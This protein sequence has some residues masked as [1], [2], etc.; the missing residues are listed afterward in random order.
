MISEFLEL[1]DKKN[2]QKSQK[3]AI[4]NF[5]RFVYNVDKANFEEL[6][7]EYIQKHTQQE[8]FHDIVKYAISLQSK[9]RNTAQT[10]LNNLQ[11]FLLWYDVEFTEKQKRMIQQK[12]N[13]A[14]DSI[15]ESILTKDMIRSLIEHTDL[16]TRSLILTL[17][18]SGMRVS[19]AL[20]L[21]LSDIELDTGCICIKK[22][23][24]K[25]NKARYTFMS[26]EALY[27]LKE[28]LKEREDYINSTYKRSKTK[29]TEIELIYPFNYVTALR[30]FISGLE[31]AKLKKQDTKQI[32]IHQLRKYFRSNMALG[33]SLDIVEALLGHAGY[34]THSYRKYSREQLETEY[35]KNENLV[36]IY[37]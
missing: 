29:D 14:Q 8:I 35:K 33:C 32:H 28:W 16:K 25:T 30:G 31:R 1:T 22:E 13:H 21:K 18:S 17:V 3:T 37:N 24:T 4:Q 36:H 34:L 12:L 9:N 7:K 15:E 26:S 6:A 23:Y 5:F 2:T 11:S 10:Y 19:E 27:T 20:H